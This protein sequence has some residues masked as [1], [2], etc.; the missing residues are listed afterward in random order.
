MAQLLAYFF[1]MTKE[2]K[3]SKPTLDDKAAEDREQQ[4]LREHAQA[5]IFSTSKVQTAGG[6]MMGGGGAN[7]R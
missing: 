6:S 1:G 3:P 5:A 4:E 2:A 7:Q